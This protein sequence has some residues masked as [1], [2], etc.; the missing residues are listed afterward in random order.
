MRKG[1]N[2]FIYVSELAVTLQKIKQLSSAVS[3]AVEIY[4]FADDISD[5]GHHPSQFCGHVEFLF[6]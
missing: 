6:G 3:R 4:V 1:E 2:K 5:L